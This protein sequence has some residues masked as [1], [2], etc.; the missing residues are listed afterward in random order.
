MN[1]LCNLEHS[2]SSTP[3]KVNV[4]LVNDKTLFEHVLDL[5]CTNT[6]LSIPF[7]IEPLVPQKL[8][9]IYTTT[10]SNIIKHPLTITSIL[11]DDFYSMGKILYSGHANFDQEFLQ[12][13]EANKIY[14][15]QPITDSNRL[16]FTGS[17]EY[18]LKWP[19]YKNI[20]ILFHK[21]W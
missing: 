8:K 15:N 20:F 19:L 16:D 12:Y 3:L 5:S 6:E 7:T 11:L 13:A 2:L 4:R 1:I 9:L 21:W 14:L 17:L 18:S 10:D